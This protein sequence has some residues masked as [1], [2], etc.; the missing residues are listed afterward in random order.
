MDVVVLNYND[1][2]TTQRFVDSIKDFEIVKHILIVDNCSSDNSFSFLKKIYSSMSNV[3][4]IQ[5]ERNGGYGYGNNY[6]ILY[7]M[8]KYNSRY[9]LLSNPDVIVEEKTLKKLLSFLVE[10]EQYSIVAPFMCNKEGIRQYN[11][12][13]KIP[14]KNQYISSLGLLGSKK[15]RFYYKDIL[16]IS[17]KFDVDCVSGSMFLMNAT[18]MVKYG[19]YD[20]NI[21]L[22]CEE[23]V[24]G[25]KLKK[26]GLK[27]CLLA[28]ERFVH[29]H[30]ISISKTF[31]SEI[32]KRKIL[33]KS[34]LYVLKKYFSINFFQL[35]YSILLAYFSLFELML[36]TLIRRIKNAQK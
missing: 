13:F 3:L 11:T 7:L 26:A 6:G 5:T 16:S 1:Y 30:S 32:K 22:Y 33:I 28:D 31:N 2:I 24:L 14:S 9:I 34:K 23:I 35:V 4:I 18:Q 29:N 17:G 15:K 20:E 27:C 25:I 8:E 12:A 21:F 10:N 36:L 19:L